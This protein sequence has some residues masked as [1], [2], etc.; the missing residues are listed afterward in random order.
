MIPWWNN[1]MTG[2]NCQNSEDHLKLLFVLKCLYYLTVLI[3]ILTFCLYL[4]TATVGPISVAINADSMRF[5]S[6][7]VFNNIFCSSKL[8]HAALAV[9]Y[10]IENGKDYWLIKNSWGT[11]WGEDGYIKMTRNF[12]NQCGIAS[13]A[14][15]PN[16]A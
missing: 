13:R 16:I 3:S 15:Y 2:I 10:G 9:G 5:Y 6:H 12:Y 11:K 7:G 14:S 4:S 8:N 1:N